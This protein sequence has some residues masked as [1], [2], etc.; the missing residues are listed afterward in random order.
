MY[1]YIFPSSYVQ[2]GNIPIRDSPPTPPHLTPPD[3]TS[4]HPTPCWGCA[5][6]G[7]GGRGMGWGG[8]G[9]PYR[10]DCT[11]DIGYWTSIY[12][13]IYRELCENQLIHQAAPYSSSCL[14][15]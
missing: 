12:I 8:G 11:L 7:R 13:Y 9:I 15:N 1:T 10:Y 2:Y 4:P 6:R 14:T 3:P 5:Q